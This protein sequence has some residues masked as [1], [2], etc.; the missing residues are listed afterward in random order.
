MAAFFDEITEKQAEF[1]GKQHVFFVATA[2]QEGRVNLSP[3]G[4]DSFRVIDPKTVAYL[5]LTGSGNETA[6]H[7]KHDGRI[8]FMM[9][10][11]DQKPN[12]LRL[13]GTGE[14][15]DVGTP[16]F[17]KLMQHFEPV[18]GQRRIIVATISSTQDSCG[19]SVPRM[20]YLEDRHTLIDYCE[21]YS[22]EELAERMREQTH[23]IDGLTIR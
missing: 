10:S 2:H 22:P 13:Y 9:C 1:I 18:T 17:E 19:Y 3:K 7:L 15:H 23:S 4:L 5:E 12:I 20:E 8:T 6:A 21:K 11:F 16:E 14:A